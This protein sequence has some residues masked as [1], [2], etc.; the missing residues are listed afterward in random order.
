MNVHCV[1]H[2]HMKVC[3]SINLE[4]GRT[5]QLWYRFSAYFIVW[6][7]CKSTSFRNLMCLNMPDFC[8]LEL[9]HVRLTAK[10]DRTL[11]FFRMQISFLSKFIGF[12]FPVWLVAILHLVTKTFDEILFFL[13]FH[14][15]SHFRSHFVYFCLVIFWITQSWFTVFIHVV[16]VSCFVNL[17]S[18][19]YLQHLFLCNFVFSKISFQSHSSFLSFSSVIRSSFH[20]LP[21]HSSFGCGCVERVRR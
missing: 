18:T 1:W 15:W 2:T 10:F 3:V 19:N 12:P 16:C 4:K 11:L 14:F 6:T 9:L 21:N 7:H 5:T 20:A 8:I 17:F 13:S